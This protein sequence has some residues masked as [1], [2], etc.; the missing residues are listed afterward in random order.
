MVDRRQKSKLQTLTA[1]AFRVG[2]GYDVHRTRPGRDLKLGGVAFPNAGFSLEGHSDADVLLHAACDAL[3]G[4]SGFADIGT[5]FPNT[6]PRHRRRNSLDFLRQVGGILRARGVS[7]VNLDCSLVAE[8]PK[9][10]GKVALMRRRMA[11]ALG[12][13]PDQVA[14]KATTNEGLGFVGR[15]EG[16]A[17]FAVS[18]VQFNSSGS[19][20]KSK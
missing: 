6:D 18:L 4:A 15:Q 10:A 20:K 14:V 13:L 17:A 16:L 12:I 9:I 7:V 3:L 2:F 5:W 1:P 11:K 19:P 8:A